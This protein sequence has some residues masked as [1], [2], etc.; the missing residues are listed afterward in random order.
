MGVDD[1]NSKDPAT[2]T[3]QNNVVRVDFAARKKPKQ[4]ELTQP[5]SSSELGADRP[6]KLRVFS[7]LIERGM[8]M[9]TTDARRDNVRVPPRLSGELQLNLNFSHKFGLA[10]FFYD[11]D[12]VRCSLS[13]NGQP[14]FC[15]IP[16]PAVWG[17]TS[18]ADGERVLW[19][20]SLP[21]ELR[22]LLPAQARHPKDD[23]GDD[24]PPPP[25]P[26]RPTLRRI[27]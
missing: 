1:D 11:D 22:T 4:P 25:S 19:P 9:V 18:H 6:E 15:D 7:R 8:V 5:S 13:F 23:D 12:G 2:E 3:T 14:F 20:D 27:K 10:D 24:P 16:W 17:L 26:P 21:E